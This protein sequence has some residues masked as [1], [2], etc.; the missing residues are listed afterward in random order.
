MI[1]TFQKLKGPH[2]DLNELLYVAALHQ[3]CQRTRS[4]ASIGSLDVRRFLASRHGIFLTHFGAIQ[5][6]RHL[7]GGIFQPKAESTLRRVSQK[8]TKQQ[9]A[10][11][12]QK[13][14][15]FVLD[16][17][18]D[19][20]GDE[21]QVPE[22]EEYLDL[23]QMLALLIIPM[24]AKA[25]TQLTDDYTPP[26]D[27]L[28]LLDTVRRV[29]RFLL[30]DILIG[31]SDNP[32]EHPKISATLVQELLLSLGETERAED[33]DLIRDMVE[34]ASSSEGTFDPS[35][36]LCALAADLDDWNLEW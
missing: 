29:H 8:G 2:A 4:N 20:Q 31:S 32:N 33:A 5:L 11:L 22:L 35:S 25:R 19:E 26:S 9:R 15:D 28:N 17:E 3:T 13:S 23:V 24:L 6:V 36:F 21:N 27:K 30:H 7:G 14:L 16:E 18:D 12:M 1:P 10:S 34:L